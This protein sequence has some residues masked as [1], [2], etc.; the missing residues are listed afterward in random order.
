MRT[1]TPPLGSRYSGMPT[2]EDTQTDL[3]GELDQFLA[4]VPHRVSYTEV[5]RHELMN[6]LLDLRD[7]LDKPSI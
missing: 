7:M 3:L 5:E 4:A 2:A 6:L 1:P